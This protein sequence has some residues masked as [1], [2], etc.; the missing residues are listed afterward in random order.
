MTQLVVEAAEL[1]V[2][3]VTVRGLPKSVP[4][5][6]PDDEIFRVIETIKGG[7]R[8]E[9]FNRRMD[10]LYGENLRDPEGNP[11]NMKRGTRGMGQ[12]A[13][14][15]ESINTSDAWFMCAAAIPK[16]NRICDELLKI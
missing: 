14:Y 7:T 4:T 11:P 10:I 2:N 8:W 1:I 13:V 3:I 9:T 6:K 12:L 5:A 16:L 15:L